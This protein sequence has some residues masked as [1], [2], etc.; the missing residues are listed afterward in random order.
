MSEIKQ[1][2]VL[3]H[4]VNVI[5]NAIADS[6]VDEQSESVSIIKDGNDSIHV[7]QLFDD[8][9]KIA[10]IFITDKKEILYSEDLLETLEDIAQTA[11]SDANL[12]KAL[13]ATK[14][15]VNDLSLQTEFILQEVKAAFDELS[16]S[17]EFGK[18][19]EK[20][21]EEFSASY[22]FGDNKFDITVVNNADAIKLEAKIDSA[23]KPAVKKTIEADV[24][25][26][27]KALNNSFK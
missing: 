25:K 10:S 6:K 12:K 20:N 2:P 17:Y 23:V 1:Y 4:I 16:D 24:D 21:I 18:T 14:I 11:K 22:K 27:G 26:I 3:K 19:T 5:K 8:T 13:E 7:K 9:D 15:I